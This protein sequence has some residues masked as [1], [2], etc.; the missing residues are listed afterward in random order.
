MIESVADIVFSSARRHGQRIALES[1]SDE[2]TY[3]QLAHRVSGIACLLAESGVRKYDR[4]AV[5]SE[6]R[7]ESVIATFATFLA[8]GVF[9]P[10]N[11]LL[12]EN[13][14]DYLLNDCS[15]HT[16][17]TTKARLSALAAVLDRCKSLRNILLLDDDTGELPGL[18]PTVIAWPDDWSKFEWR[19]IV[20]IV[21]TDVAAIMYTSGSTGKPKGVVLSHGNLCI[22][23]ASVSQ[24]LENSE[25]DRILALLPFSFDAGFSQLTTGLL[26][27][28]TVILHNYLLPQDV[29]RIVAARRVTGITGVPPLWMQLAEQK[30]PSPEQSTLRYF[31]NT[32]G[33]MPQAT[34][35]TL[36]KNFPFAKPYLMYGLTES[37]RSTYLPPEDVDRKPGSIGKAIPNV[38]ISVVADDGSICKPG[39]S[40]ELVHSGPLV[41]L[42][43]WNDPERTAERFRPAPGRPDELPIPDLAVWSGDIVRCD[44]EGFLYFVGRNDDMIKTSG[45]RVSPTEIEELAF[46]SGY[47]AE[48]IAIG[49]PYE[50]LGQAIILIA[51]AR[52]GQNASSGDLLGSVRRQAPNYMVPKAVV[53]MEKLP[54]NANGKI[55]RPSLT[56]RFSNYFEQD[57]GSTP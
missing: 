18:R 2:T 13:Q 26:S 30:W 41:S 44:E 25:A 54:R 20:R 36:R 33:R 21:P 15:V 32:G 51:K 43:Y 6:K 10:V 49:V 1:G 34:L 57:Q 45:Y 40:G 11:S 5:F 35:D 56:A 27:G 28:A 3:E 55:D 7:T 37:F 39:D 52:H 29:V 31:A 22:G 19:R 53:W 48:A 46:E 47:V 9:V 17:V 12:K 16:L 24:Y 23:A 4:V 42:G 14:I 50:S 38:E 8:G